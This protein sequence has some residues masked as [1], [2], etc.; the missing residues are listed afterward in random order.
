MNGAG[1]VWN[2]YTACKINDSI[3]GLSQLITY[4]LQSVQNELEG[5]F[6]IFD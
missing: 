6:I 4:Q 5:G 1:L 2:E 3:T